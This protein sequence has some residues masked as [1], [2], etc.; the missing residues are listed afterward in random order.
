[1]TANISKVPAEGRSKPGDTDDSASP[2]D[3]FL[4]ASAAFSY[5]CFAPLFQPRSPGYRQEPPARSPSVGGQDPGGGSSAEP[6]CM[7][8]HVHTCASPS[9][10]TAGPSFVPHCSQSLSTCSGSRLALPLQG[11]MMQYPFSEFLQHL[12]AA[13]FSSL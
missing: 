9:P 2:V 10:L 5:D 13:P 11:S 4:Q 8:I 1:M 3:R 12:M 7:S 6:V